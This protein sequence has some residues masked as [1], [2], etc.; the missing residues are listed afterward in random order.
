MF[1]PAQLDL[2]IYQGATFR[3]TFG[4]K[5]SSL[6][7]TGYTARMQI[8][9][10]IKNSTVVADLTTE[11][12][13]IIFNYPKTRTCTPPVSTILD[14]GSIIE[15]SDAV[16]D[17]NVINDCFPEMIDHELVKPEPITTILD[18]ESFSFDMYISADD[19]SLLD[20]RNGV[21][22]LEFVS[23]IGDVIRLLFGSVSLDP[24]VTR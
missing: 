16:I 22:D 14:H 20:F 17:Y 8:R 3:K 13:G 9:E 23:P 7:L 10:K 18:G 4:W 5:S 1:K 24:E 21:Y 15:I 11:N 12:G 19:T 6:D 2:I